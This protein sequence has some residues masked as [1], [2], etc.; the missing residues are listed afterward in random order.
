MENAE[1]RRFM[2]NLAADNRMRSLI[3]RDILPA[4][5]PGRNAEETILV[6]AMRLADMD[7]EL[8]SG[9]DPG[10]A[11][12]LPFRRLPAPRVNRTAARL[13]PA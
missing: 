1:Y 13:C 3:A 5:L 7:A 4:D 12:V 9:K 2:H 11:V 6:L 10:R 8:R